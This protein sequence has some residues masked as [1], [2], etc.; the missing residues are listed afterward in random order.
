MKISKLY[1]VAI[2]TKYLLKVEDAHEGTYLCC[3]VRIDGIGHDLYF[4]KTTGV[5]LRKQLTLKSTYT[6]KTLHLIPKFYFHC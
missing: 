3:R 1:Y 5:F 6:P 4:S 2:S